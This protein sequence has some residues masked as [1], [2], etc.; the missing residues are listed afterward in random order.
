V[1][2][3]IA[4]WV[5]LGVL[6]SA[7]T[8]TP[9]A[10]PIIVY[11]TPA[12]PGATLATPIPRIRVASTP[13]PPPIDPSLGKVTFGT[14]FDKETLAIDRGDSTFARG[15]SKICW[16]A[17]LSDEPTHATIRR[18]LIRS[19]SGGTETQLHRWNEDITNPKFTNR[20]NCEDWRF[21]TRSRAGTYTLR[22][23]DGVKNVAEGKFKL[24]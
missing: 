4:A 22:F 11:V 20:A 18:Y 8:S 6:A 2:R 7:C 14:H 23:V 9:A 24:N 17:I 10:T 1:R 16:N 13:A 3:S 19:G 5:V 15:A 12:P 21:Y